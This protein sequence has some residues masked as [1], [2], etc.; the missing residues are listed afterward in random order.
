LYTVYPEPGASDRAYVGCGGV[1][2]H[3]TIVDW[4]WTVAIEACPGSCLPSFYIESGA[5]Q[6]QAL[7]GQDVVVYGSFGWSVE[8]FGLFLESFEWV[9]CEVAVEESSWS[10]M[11]SL[12]Q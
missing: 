4:G 9:P 11:K 3:G 10:N 7:I 12:F 6:L 8:G 5:E 2:G 1:A